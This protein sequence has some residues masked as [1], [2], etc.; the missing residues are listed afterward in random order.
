MAKDPRYEVLRKNLHD[1]R[2]TQPERANN[3][4]SPVE[5]AET[6]AAIVW[7]REKWGDERPCP[8]CNNPSYFVGPPSPFALEAGG[9]TAPQVPVICRN[10]GVTALIDIRVIDEDEEQ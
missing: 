7:L 4:L 6:A 8:Y 3:D 5:D 1:W 2:E 10:C 9:A